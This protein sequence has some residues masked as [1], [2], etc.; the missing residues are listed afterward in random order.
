MC[1]LLLFAHLW[2]CCYQ[3]L[4]SLPLLYWTQSWANSAHFPPSRSISL[5]FILMLSSCLI[6]G[7]PSGLIQRV[8]PLKLCTHILSPTSDLHIRSIVISQN[9]TLLTILDDMYKFLSSL[10]LQTLVI[11][12]FT[13]NYRTR[14]T[15]TQNNWEFT[16]LCVFH[17]F[18]GDR[19][20]RT[21]PP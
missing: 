7:L 4:K 16:I 9:F 6:L 21:V 17:Y 15:S 19:G 13:E 12:F 2:P 5:R 20:V 14:F 18:C 10:C 3:R 1:S 8:S 11:K